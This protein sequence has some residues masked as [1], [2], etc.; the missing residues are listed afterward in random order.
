MLEL[1]IRDREL[2]AGERG[3]AR[4]IAM[5]ILV[6]MAELQQAT[7][8]ID[9]TRAHVD[10]CH[11]TGEASVQ[12]AESLAAHGD[13]VAVPTSMNAISLD[14]ARWR[15]QGVADEWAGSA[16]RIVQAYLRMGARSSFT[17]APYQ[18]LDPPVAGE[19]IAWAE[20]NAIAFANGVL[21][22]RTNRYGDFMDICAAL[23]GRVPLAGYHLDSARLGDVLVHLPPMQGLDQAFYPVLGYLVGGRVDRGV[24]VITGL[25]TKPTADDLKAFCAAVATSGSVAM[26]HVVGVTPEAPTIE[27]AFGGKQP[28]NRWA[29]HIAELAGAWR[30]LTTAH[31]SSVDLV[32]LGSP[33]FSL[34]ECQRLAEMVADRRRHPNVE[35]LIT[36]NRIVYDAATRTGVAAVLERFGARFATDTCILLSPIVPDR[37]RTLMTNSAKYAHYAP[38]LLGRDVYFGNL[39]DCVLTAVSGR[40]VISE[41]TWL[42]E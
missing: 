26:F 20:S 17:C 29:V 2:L 21:G 11:Y 23:T 13:T 34:A 39:A 33:H 30:E 36:T 25:N 9:I 1:D 3:P 12:F 10:G 28:G 38:G 40:P 8:F 27:A 42:R 31:D 37:S 22:A 41:P 4:K 35:V 7:R 14:R 5:R 16:E 15:E 6:R 18:S 24:P 32:V 19:H